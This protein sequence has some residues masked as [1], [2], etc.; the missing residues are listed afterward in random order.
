MNEIK[1]GTSSESINIEVP[2][3]YSDDGWAQA[4][5]EIKT[6]NFNGAITAWVELSDFLLFSNSLSVLYKTLQGSAIFESTEGQIT[7]KLEALAG[8]QIKMSGV[9]WSEA[10]YGSKLDFSFYLDQ[11]FLQ[12]PMKKLEALT[13]K[14]LAKA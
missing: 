11:T 10:C 8:G 6:C 14:I 2:L 9:A 7:L 12:E 3:V 5:V 13:I 1:I 4:S